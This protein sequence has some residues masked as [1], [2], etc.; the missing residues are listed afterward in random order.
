VT[1]HRAGWRKMQRFWLVF[2]K[3][4]VQ[5]SAGTP[6]VISTALVIF[7]STSITPRRLPSKS[8]P[9]HQLS[10]HS[11]FLQS[12]YWQL[13]KVNSTHEQ[14]WPRRL[15]E[16]VTLLI[17]ILEVPGLNLGRGGDYYKVFSWFCSVSPSKCQDIRSI[18][19]TATVSFDILSD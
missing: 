15:V 11:T 18:S 3:C 13:R 1:L 17:C 9:I 6:L 2:G 10:Y 12:W 5:I 16:A 4:L 7:L 14:M 19:Q 8:F